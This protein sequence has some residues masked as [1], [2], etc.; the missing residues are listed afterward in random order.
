MGTWIVGAIVLFII[1]LAGYKV[2][3][4]K[5]NGKGCSSGCEGCSG[6]PSSAEETLH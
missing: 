2:F 4:D 3:K 5:K 1:V 6:C